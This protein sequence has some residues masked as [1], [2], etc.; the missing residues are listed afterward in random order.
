MN[1]E[2]SRV[3]LSF[4]L[5]LA[6]LL[7]LSCNGNSS[8]PSE[9]SGN[10][11]QPNEQEQAVSLA[12]EYLYDSMDRHFQTFS[13]YTDADAGGNHFAPSGYFNGTTSLE[14]NTRW[15]ENPYSGTSCIQVVWNGT[16]GND[17]WSWNG[18][19]FE[20]PQG[21]LGQPTG[22]GYD[23]TGATTLTFWARTD[24]PGLKVQFGMGHV[25]DASGE[26]KQ[27]FELGLH[28]KKYEIDL[29]GID[30]S[31]VHGGFL[32]VVN[33]DNDPD[34]D[35]TVFY[36]DE[37]AYD[38]TRPDAL[39]LIP[40]FT[41]VTD[42]D[43][44]DIEN[45]NLATIYDNALAILA[46]LERDTEKDLSR[47][48]ILADAL[49]FANENDTNVVPLNWPFAPP[50][51][52]SSRLKDGYSTGD[53]K[54]AQ[55]NFRYP[56]WWDY[57]E[58]MWKMHDLALSYRTGDLAWAMIALTGLYEVTGKQAYL[59]TVEEM[60]EWIVSNCE[61]AGSEINGG[62]KGG[63]VWSWNQLAWQE[64]GVST[65]HNIDLAAAF[66]ELAVLTGD[67]VWQ[68]R[69]DSARSFVEAMW[70]TD[71]AYFYTGLNTDSAISDVNVLDVQAWAA[72]LFQTEPYWSSLDWSE[73]NLSPDGL[74]FDFNDDLDGTWYEGIAHMAAAFRAR[75]DEE[76][77]VALLDIL[78]NAQAS[79]PNVNGQGI[80]G[81]DT[82]SLTTGLSWNYYDRLSLGTT[83]WFLIAE[84][85]VNPF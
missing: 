5:S 24:E 23:L 14:I 49:I 35:G 73:A 25:N 44:F 17:G 82:Y 61:R 45:K 12:Y 39:R 41:T 34:P 19:L 80:P 75:G 60:G 55:G 85:G 63:W 6:L 8:S 46:L 83:C 56:G 43:S 64:S 33:N 9:N 59:T 57:D 27:W 18:L 21:Y 68:T 10:H 51:F 81:A 48:G 40:S 58:K 76:K 29:T 71:E 30:L 16:P 32:F 79:G 52:S 53:L 2:A 65:E 42:T 47:A 20:E 11:T 26:K 28:W 3:C 74:Y 1:P 77:A 78:R 69:S 62:Y 37:I 72:M 22:N 15:T 66:G 4:L 54:D 38:L 50:P 67:A 31:N 13:V 70:N 7:I 84:S 36:I